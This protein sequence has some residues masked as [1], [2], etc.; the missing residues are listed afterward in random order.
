MKLHKA[1]AGSAVVASL[2]LSAGGCELIVSPDR[3]KIEPTGGTGGGGTGGGGTG[4]TTGGGGTGGTTGGGGTGGMP[5]VPTDD[6]KECTDDVCN[7]DGTTAH[8]PKTA[9]DACTEGG[10][11][12]CDGNGNCVGCLQDANCTTPQ[13]CDT[14]TN[15]CVDPTC[16]DV[17]LDGDETDVDCGGLVC[18]PCID[19]K[20]CL[21]AG[22]C[23][24]GV[25]ADNGSGMT[26]CQTA[27]CG[28][29][30]LNGDETDVDCGGS[31]AADCAD[32]LLCLVAADCQSGVCADDGMG[33]LKCSAPICG[34]NVVNGTD[35]CDDGNM[36]NG[37][38]CDN[39]CK[40]SECGNGQVDPATEE[41]DDNNSVNG[42]G[43]DN[44]CK[45]TACGN[46]VVTGTEVCDD[47]N[48]V[49]GDGCD[50]NCTNTGCGNT[51]VTA[52]ETCDDGG[53]VDGDGCDSNCTNTGCGNNVVTMGEACDDGNNVNGDGCDD[54][55][56]ASGCGNGA[57]DPATEQ[58]DD[59]NQVDDDGCDSTCKTTGCGSGVVTGTEACD[60]GNTAAGDGCD[61]ACTVEPGFYCQGTKPSV[62]AGA[63]ILCGDG[64]D[65]NGAFGADAADPSCA[66]PAYVPACAPSTTL[67]VYPN[68]TSTA[69]PDN[70]LTGITSNV[71]VS[72]GG[73][74][75]GGAI[76]FTIP[77]EYDGDVDVSLIT[78]T[79]TTIDICS[80]N[81]GLGVNFTNTVLSPACVPANA[82]T[83]GTAP[84]SGCYIPENNA[85]VLGIVGK[86]ADGTW[87]L[88]VVDDAGGDVG[89][90][91]SWKLVL[92][93]TVCGD[94]TMA[95]AEQCDDGNLTDGDGCDSNCKTTACG[96]GITTTGETCDDGNTAANDGCSA[97]CAPEAGYNCTGTP[98][99]CTTSCGD[100]TKA[101]AEACDD[102]GINPG[103]GCSATCTVEAGYTCTGSTP[104]VCTLN[105]GNGTL[106]AGEA[107]D[108]GNPANGDGCSSACAVEAGYFCAGTPSTCAMPEVNCNDG[109]DNN[110][111][112]GVDAADPSCQLPA[113]F[114]ACAAGE[115]FYVGL[116]TDTP[117]PIPDNTPAGAVSNVA[118]AGAGGTIAR[119]AVMLDIAHTWD[120][121]VDIT[122][123]SPGAVNFDLSSDNGGSNDNY[124]NT[125]LDTTCA[126][127]VTAGTAPFS[128]CYKPEATLA[129]LAGTT[130][131]GTWT[132]KAVDDA[133]GIAGTLNTWKIALC[134]ATCGDGVKTASEGCDD[135]GTTGGDGC[136]ATC[137]VESG[138]T[139]T[140]QGA[141]SCTDN[142][143]CVLN[144][145]NCDPNATCS[146]T[147]GSFTCACNPGYS[148]SGVTCTDDDECALN[149]D[150]CDPN[151]T[152]TNTPGTFTC[153]CNAGYV[154]N[155][156]TCGL[157]ASCQ[158]LKTALPATVD[159]DYPID[160]DA[161][162]VGLPFTVRCDMTTAGGGWTLAF[163][164]GTGFDESL[165]GGTAQTGYT[166]NYINLAYS[167]VAITGDVMIDASDLAISGT[168]Q[169]LR[170]VI[171]GVPA[172]TVGKTM[173]ELFTAGGP[174]RFDLEDNSNVSNTFAGGLDCMTLAKW[175]D[176]RTVMCGTPVLTGRDVAVGGLCDG[177]TATLGWDVSYTVAQSNCAG[178]PEDPNFGGNNYFP[179]NVRVWVR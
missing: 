136:S 123:T 59:G 2:L 33:T 116:A 16:T 35:G 27:S 125:V 88:K 167:T 134:T 148:G 117:K 141:G 78:P 138:Y 99:V 108:D 155:G 107:C 174:Y 145:D 29:G 54:N 22:D 133:G 72:N 101:G 171:T 156:V 126:T 6:M 112:L 64:L 142:D 122:L 140:G 34:D 37:D 170:S 76:V 74:V 5:C 176:Y 56:T 115:K 143:E 131:N 118:I 83:G 46:G 43:C 132:L 21:V 165:N 73:T 15:A 86:S 55:C 94:G 109:L 162:G 82:V 63:E 113:Y 102:G 9:G 51:I 166:T 68:N 30:V 23:E 1:L 175:D 137:T 71:T 168:D 81:G 39:N 84:F 157:T 11:A 61:A 172:A 47:G 66:L 95:G 41:C 179:D 8:N 150:N 129:T 105:C 103:D 164:D 91:Q 57:V 97:A 178:W 98:S 177:T 111:V 119:A 19:G 87:G 120:S 7:A 144:T 85:Q 160:P 147:P 121:D 93:T 58:C 149:T 128:G 3:S 14:T 114:P 104:S 169:E 36:V 17:K 20:L 96:N 42:D 124:T 24:S 38:G 65:N 50:N 69:I 135:G 89:T 49:N 154:G 18:D 163:N 80:D 10:G 4:G 153:A 127:N 53:L 151:A 146:N 90:L 32:T 44:N 77:H 161:A 48:A 60:D 31:C 62:C 12:V 110:G 152:C 13:V 40:P 52:G 92:C 25:C 75:A 67:R 106:Q 159:G 130:P 28:D 26:T 173:R 158:A 79:P 70:N 100:G 139:C 45:T